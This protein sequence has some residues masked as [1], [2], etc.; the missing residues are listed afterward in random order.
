MSYSC[1][2]YKNTG[3]DTTNIPD[4]I[5]L[6]NSIGQPF[7]VPALDILQERNLSTIRVKARWDTVKDVDYCMLYNNSGAVWL[8][9][10]TNIIMENTDTASLS[11][12][13][14][15]I[16]SVGGAANLQIIDGITERVH[17]SD[18]SYGK[19]DE[20]D[21]LLN[22]TQVMDIET[23][24]KTVSGKGPTVVESTLNVGA[25][26]N[27]RAKTYEDPNSPD[28]T[29][30]VPEAKP[31]HA[32]KFVYANEKFNKPGTMLFPVEYDGETDHPNNVQLTLNRN[33]L[34]ALRSLGLDQAIVNQVKIPAA[35]VHFDNPMSIQEID[36]EGNPVSDSG[37]FY[38][39]VTGLRGNFD[40]DEIPYV[41]HDGVKNIRLNYSQRE[42]YGL[43]T[44]SGSSAEFEPAA[45]Y[46]DGTFPK[47]TWEADP[48][49]DGAP[50]FRYKTVNGD[51]SAKGFW[52]NC[53]KGLPWKQVPLIFTTKSGTLLETQKFINHQNLSGG[54]AQISQANGV[55]GMISS[56]IPGLMQTSG[57]PQEEAWL[58]GIDAGIGKTGGAYFSP[59]LKADTAVSAGNLLAN[60]MMYQEQRRSELYDFVTSQN[61]VVPTV[62]FPYNSEMIRDEMGN[63]VLAYRYKYKN[64]DLARIDKLLT[65]YGYK[66]TKPLETSDFTNRQFFNFV[67]A[68]NVAV[69][70]H[71][72]WI[73]TEI[74]NQLAA[75][76]RVWHTK[77]DASKYVSGNPIV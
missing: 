45:I 42:S 57:G 60:K 53:L 25:T 6:L 49:T 68:K 7:D 64:D 18:D 12:V 50:Y 15:M 37:V 13:V 51:N 16:N 73:N 48:H 21:V 22:P 8:Y 32:T 58:Q 62:N 75:G 10:V 4:S 40:L 23:E 30:S 36:N 5:G 77:P 46:G 69:T 55:W 33:N 44:C 65:M 2:L 61:A 9:A 28:I 17:V 39:T 43:I 1:R 74:K 26:V 3:F 63:G 59:S 35:Y 19:W 47:I 29:V 38:Q 66:V 76:V 70:G 41:L 27:G 14:D 67:Q 56:L 24:W 54:A 52:R 31:A 11:V 71:A 20:D 34:A 72:A